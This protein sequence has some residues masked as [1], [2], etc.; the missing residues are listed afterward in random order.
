[1]AALARIHEASEALEYNPGELLLLQ[2]LL[3]RLST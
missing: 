3:A 1:L 2:A